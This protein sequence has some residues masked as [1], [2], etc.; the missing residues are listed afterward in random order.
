[1][2]AIG[3]HHSNKARTDVWLTPPFLLALLGEFDL[4]PC[5]AIGQPWPTAKQHYTRL[6]DGLSK[7]W[8]G[9]VWL[10]PPYGAEAERWLARMAQHRN[11][12]ALIFAR[13]ETGAFFRYVWEQAD[14]LLFLRGRLH[15]HHSDGR[16]AAANAGGPSVLIAYGQENVATLECRADLGRFVSLRLNHRLRMDP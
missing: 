2:S 6:D 9:R 7:P 16:R 5:A 1:M 12:M 15:F 4:D 3:G 8:F 14:A 11:G 10:N 13:T